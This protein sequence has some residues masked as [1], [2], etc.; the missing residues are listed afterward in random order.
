M[1]NCSLLARCTGLGAAVSLAVLTLP[2]P[3]RAD[4][5][6][7]LQTKCSLKGAA[8]VP[9]SVEAVNDAGATLYHHRIGNRTITV[10]ISDKPVRMALW[11]ASS[12]QW[13]SLERAAALFSSNTVCFDGAALCVVN[14]NYLNSVRED[15]PAAMAKRD[16][17]KVHFGADGRINA[18]CYDEG[19]EV[20]QK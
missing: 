17:V 15:N 10:R 8:P 3:G 6:Y 7:T 19:C 20:V 4:V 18:S 11:N 16:L 2:L 12:K 13:Q 14:A 1:P 5:L 9:C